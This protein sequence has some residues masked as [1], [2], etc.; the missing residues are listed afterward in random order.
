MATNEEEESN[1]EERGP[2]SAD[3]TPDDALVV[4]DAAGKALDGDESE[5]VSFEGGAPAHLGTTKYVQGAFFAAGVLVAYLSGNI[6][7]AI[8]NNL[9]EWPAVVRAVPQLLTYA[10]DE[11]PTLMMPLGALLGI[12]FVFHYA[13]QDRVRQWADEVATELYKVHWPERSVVTNGTIVV[14]V[15]GALATLYV[16]LLDRVWGFVTNLVY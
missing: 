11:R 15:A 2:E 12:A 3:P 1:R 13:R 16:G 14:L 8:W 5:D 7:V 9:T 10:E 4:A 6:L